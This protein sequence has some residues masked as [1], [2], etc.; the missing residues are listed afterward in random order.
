MAYSRISH[1]APIFPRIKGPKGPRPRLIHFTSEI[2]WSGPLPGFPSLHVAG[3]F[4]G[5]AGDFLRW[6][7]M[8][9][10][11]KSYWG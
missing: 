4:H 6:K 8:E 5:V 10:S 3:D 2:S 1:R 11:E 9:I 7:V